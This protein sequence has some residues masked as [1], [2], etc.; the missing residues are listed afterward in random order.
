LHRAY[1]RAIR[2]FIDWYCSEPR[3]AFNKT[4]V[5]RYPINLEQARYAASI[6][7][8]RLAPVICAA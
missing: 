1:D 6:V 8:L 7:N 3:R 2:D 4:V 5:T